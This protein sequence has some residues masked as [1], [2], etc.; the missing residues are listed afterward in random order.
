MGRSSDQYSFRFSE[1]ENESLV[2]IAENL[3][4]SIPPTWRE[5]QRPSVP[6]L[7]RA[8]ANGDLKLARNTRR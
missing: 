7:I 5:P 8:I 1:E 3:N 6:A 2:K 4:I